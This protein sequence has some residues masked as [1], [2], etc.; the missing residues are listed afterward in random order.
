[1]AHART[2]DLVPID[3]QGNARTNHEVMSVPAILAALRT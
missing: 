1:M 3:F 2:N